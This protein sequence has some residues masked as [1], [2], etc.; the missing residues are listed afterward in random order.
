MTCQAVTV[1]SFSYLKDLNREDFRPVQ[2]GK[3]VMTM[4]TVD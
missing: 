3:Q 4:L 2:L 1:G